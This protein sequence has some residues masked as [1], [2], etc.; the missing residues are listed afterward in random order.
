MVSTQQSFTIYAVSVEQ[1]L[2]LQ[3]PKRMPVGREQCG[4]YMY[5]HQL[6]HNENGILIEKK[7]AVFAGGETIC[8]GL[9]FEYGG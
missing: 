3:M 1:I 5:S 4:I 9:S 7:F 8:R 6:L 2:L